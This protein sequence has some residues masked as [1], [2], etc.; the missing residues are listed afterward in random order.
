MSNYLPSNSHLCQL[1]VVAS[2]ALAIFGLNKIEVSKYYHYNWSRLW[3]AKVISTRYIISD[4]ILLFFAISRVYVVKGGAQRDS[5]PF[6]GKIVQLHLY[7]MFCV[8]HVFIYFSLS[9]E[10]LQL[11]YLASIESW[12]TT[13][14][15]VVHILTRQMS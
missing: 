9:I 13:I 3:I 8:I 14:E 1:S 4:H 6:K 15:L 5:V 10:C 12:L 2:F 7:T 11:C